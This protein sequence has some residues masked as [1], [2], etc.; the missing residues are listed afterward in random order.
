[1]KDI[2]NNN[3]IGNIGFFNYNDAKELIRDYHTDKKNILQSI[4]LYYLEILLETHNS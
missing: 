3:E 1:M 4:Y 2:E